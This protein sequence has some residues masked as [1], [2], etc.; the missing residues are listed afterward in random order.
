MFNNISC[1]K[2]KQDINNV[3]SNSGLLPV[4]AYYILKDSLHELEDICKEV[5]E[6]E[7]KNPTEQEHE[8][9]ISLLDE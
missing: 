4:V 9:D 5:M 2:F 6:Y 8:E 3:I 7:S 1:E